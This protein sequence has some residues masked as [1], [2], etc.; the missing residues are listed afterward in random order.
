[1]LQGRIPD[2]K[3]VNVIAVVNGKEGSSIPR[4]EEGYIVADVL[5]DGATG[6]WDNEKWKIKLETVTNKEINCTISFVE[7]F[8][9]YLT[10]KSK[11]ESII[12]EFGHVATN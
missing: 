1:M 4:K 3:K 8:S 7:Y 11:E 5:C 6:S 9:D 10:A 2:F 12:E